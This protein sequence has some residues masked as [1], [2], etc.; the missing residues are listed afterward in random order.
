M[1]DFD[2]F[3]QVKVGIEEVGE[4]FLESRHYHRKYWAKMD[5]ARKAL[6]LNGNKRMAEIG[7]GALPHLEVKTFVHPILARL[8]RFGSQQP[9]FHSSQV[10]VGLI[11]SLCKRLINIPVP[12]Q[13]GILMESLG[14]GRMP[15]KEITLYVI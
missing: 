2:R 4:Y 15:W 12:Y 6:A 3:I 10:N 1:Q 5:A 9:I 14:K 7:H 13:L 8:D 11:T